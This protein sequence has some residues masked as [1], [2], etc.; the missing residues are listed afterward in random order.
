MLVGNVFDF[1]TN[2]QAEIDLDT[3]TD[4]VYNIME[5]IPEITALG[6]PINSEDGFIDTMLVAQNITCEIAGKLDADRWLELTPPT[7]I[8][9]DQDDE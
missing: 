8:I 3:L 6:V 5:S 2:G 4:H 1:S 7:S 9:E